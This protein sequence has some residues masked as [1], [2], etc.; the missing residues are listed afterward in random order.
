MY[1]WSSINE[2]CITIVVDDSI[3]FV[4]LVEKLYKRL[5]VDQKTTKLKLSYLYYSKWKKME[6]IIIESDEC[7]LA[8]LIN[9]GEQNNDRNMIYVELIRKEECEKSIEVYENEKEHRLRDEYFNRDFYVE[10]HLI[11]DALSAPGHNGVNI[12]QSTVDLVNIET[13]ESAPTPHSPPF[14]QPPQSP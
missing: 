8:Y 2:E 1:E 6:R 7:L 14:P 9:F 3:N 12:D 5:R 4:G 11:N 10:P 13:I